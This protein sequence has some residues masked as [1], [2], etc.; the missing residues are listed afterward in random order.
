MYETV[1]SKLTKDHKTLELE[2]EEQEDAGD[3]TDG[4]EDAGQN[5][6]RR[7]ENDK[8][9]ETELEPEDGEQ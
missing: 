8:M 9:L 5:W 7:M 3:R 4:E 6:S 1:L 2:D